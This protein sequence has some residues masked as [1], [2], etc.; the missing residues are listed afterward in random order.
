MLLYPVTAQS[1]C[2]RANTFPWECSLGGSSCLCSR[3]IFQNALAVSSPQVHSS[4]FPLGIHTGDLQM[5][6]RW[7]QFFSTRH[8][9]LLPGHIMGRWD[10]GLEPQMMPP[11]TSYLFVPCLE[12]HPSKGSNQNV[13][14]LS[15][16][17][18]F[19]ASFS[20]TSDFSLTL[21][22]PTS[23]KERDAIKHSKSLILCK[24][25]WW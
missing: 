1:F 22:S 8:S 21:K 18:G 16:A 7:H 2:C 19:S 3:D 24:A 6:V 20:N 12:W 5:P 13:R 15:S 23:G 14:V 25:L 11:A 9:L 10:V 4:W 17:P